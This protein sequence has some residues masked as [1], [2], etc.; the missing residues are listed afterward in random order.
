MT[1]ADDVVVLLKQWRAVYIEIP[2]VA[3][4]SIKLTLASVLGIDVDAAGGNPHTVVFPAPAARST[5][6]GH[7]YPGMFSFA[8]VRNPWDRLVSCYRDKILGEAPD[9]TS[10]DAGRGVASCLARFD[11]FQA[12]MSFERF[13]EVVAGIPDE[14]ADGHTRAQH[15]FITNALGESP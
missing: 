12:E 6:S 9:F 3:C 7:Q 8:F 1:T 10:I 15:T 13:V 2:K 14:E 11:A 4:S 5:S